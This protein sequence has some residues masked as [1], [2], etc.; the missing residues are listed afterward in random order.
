LFASDA[1]DPRPSNDTDTARRLD[2]PPDQQRFIRQLTETISWCASAG[3]LAE[4]R[5]SLRS[6]KPKL[7][8]LMSRDLQVFSVANRRSDR[9]RSVGKQSL[10]AVTDLCGGRLLA[11]IPDDNLA[12]GV[13]ETETDGFFDVDN[14]PPYDTWVWMARS[15]RTEECSDAPSRE[16][17]VDYLVAW[18]PQD[19]I[20]L[21]DR[22]VR[23]NPEQC[24]IWLDTLDDAFVQSLR[25]MNFVLKV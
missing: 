7:S 22:G 21:A 20:D 8:D 24:V 3:S 6:C 14:I 5:A 16:A 15:V 25:R 18:V 23:V 19:F 1:R 4:P 9:L 13:A 10:P 2:T 17:E 12:D 11:Y